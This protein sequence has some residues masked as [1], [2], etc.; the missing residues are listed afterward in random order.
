MGR[1][2]GLNLIFPSSTRAAN[3]LVGNGKIKSQAYGR[4]HIPDVCK[5]LRKTVGGYH[6]EYVE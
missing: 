6:W 2:G 3:W 5:G 4:N 1:G